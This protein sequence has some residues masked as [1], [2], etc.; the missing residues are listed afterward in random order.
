P[1]KEMVAGSIPAGWTKNS[2]ADY[3]VAQSVEAKRP[4]NASPL[5]RRWAK[6]KL[7]SFAVHDSCP[8][9]LCYNE[10]SRVDSIK[11]SC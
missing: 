3:A 10:A 9:R 6:D 11:L 4:A 7:L 1:F 8:L 2:T 5:L